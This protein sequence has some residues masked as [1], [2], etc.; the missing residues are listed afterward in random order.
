MTILSRKFAHI[1]TYSDAHISRYAIENI[2][3]SLLRYLLQPE[4]SL[5]A[6]VSLIGYGAEIAVLPTERESV[7]RHNF[8]FAMRKKLGYVLCIMCDHNSKLRTM[9]SVRHVRPASQKGTCPRSSRTLQ[10]SD[11]Y[12]VIA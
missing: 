3:F 5:V 10:K 9:S 2:H 6:S 1:L 8:D 12:H 11:W 4:N 7:C